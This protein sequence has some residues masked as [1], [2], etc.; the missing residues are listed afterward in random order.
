[1]KNLI[2]SELNQ[3]YWNNN[4]A[5][6]E[7]FNRLTEKFMKPEGRSEN[8][9]GE[10][11]RA[12]N[13]LYYEYCN[14]GN[15]NAIDAEEI[16]GEWIECPH[17]GGAGAG[18]VDEYYEDGDEWYNEECSECGG[19]G[20]YHEE[21]D[22]NYY[23]N[24]FYENFLKIIRHYFELQCNKDENYEGAL[25]AIDELKRVIEKMATDV[26]FSDEN[27]NRYDKVVDYI[28]YFVSNDEDN[29]TP[30]PAWYENE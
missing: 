25:E 28:T 19:E 18:Y 10:V 26:D 8:L 7:E 24:S 2:L 6:E 9:V 29:Q 16:E 3:H 11:V 15:C 22:Y 5:N 27:M 23:L 17:C 30:I 4:G 12:M 20:G 21:S 1:M 13:R 14:N